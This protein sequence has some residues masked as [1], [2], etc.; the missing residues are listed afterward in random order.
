MSKVEMSI[1]NKHWFQRL[2]EYIEARDQNTGA[3]NL[4]TPE[5][6]SKIV[7]GMFN[8]LGVG[9]VLALPRVLLDA[10]RDPFVLSECEDELAIRTLG[11]NAPVYRLSERYLEALAA[12][13]AFASDVP[14]I[15]PFRSVIHEPTPIG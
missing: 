6:A 7:A 15:I 13:R 11:A 10:L 1:E 5:V 2:A 12:I 3:A 14:L 4:V 8:E 9:G